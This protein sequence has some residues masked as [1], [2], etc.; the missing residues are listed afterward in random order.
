[1]CVCVI[2]FLVDMRWM[3]QWK[4]YI[5]YDQWDQSSAGLASANPG[6]I[7]N[8]NLFKGLHALPVTLLHCLVA[9]KN[10]KS[11]KDHLMEELDYILLPQAAWDKLVAWYGL[12]EGSS[13][14]PRQVVEYGLYMKHCKV[15]VYLL[16]FSVYEQSKGPGS[17][18]TL[19]F[20]RANTVCK[21]PCVQLMM[22]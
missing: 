10:C 20:S 14:I 21:L 17:P 9:D 18:H 11:L 16:E 13:P 22:G 12:S 7:D 1:M 2:R 19:Q 6:P 3:K 15:E 8:S 4:K 5:G